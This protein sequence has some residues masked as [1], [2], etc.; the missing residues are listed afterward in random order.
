MNEGRNLIDALH[1]ATTSGEMSGPM[2][3]T[4]AGVEDGPFDLIGPCFD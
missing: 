4:A 2:S 3:G 1:G